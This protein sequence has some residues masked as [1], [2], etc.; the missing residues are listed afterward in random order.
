MT[1]CEV[2]RKVMEIR[3]VRTSALASR[4]N[5][6]DRMVTDRLR[7]KNIS[8]DKLN[9]MLRVMDYKIVA[10]PREARVPDTGY[11]ID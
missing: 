10:L 11:E 2:V 6:P 7:Q 9:E 1:A 8:I 3:S 4:L 5:I